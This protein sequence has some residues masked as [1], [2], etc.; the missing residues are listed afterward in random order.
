MATPSLSESRGAEAGALGRQW[1]VIAALVVMIATN[2]LANA[3]PLN[4]QT[5]GAISARFPIYFEPAGYVFSIWGLIYLGLIVYAVYQALPAQRQN[6]RLRAI[7]FPFILSCLANTTWL[8]LWHYNRFTLTQ[9]AM[10]TLLLALILIY[11]RLA[12]GRPA[13][14][15]IEKWAVHLPFS[16]YLGWVTVATVANTSIVLYD[17]GWRGGALGEP[18]WAVLM[19]LVT[20]GLTFLM[21]W[22][23][24]DVAYALV[25]VWAAAGIAV[26]QSGSGLVA[27]TA[28]AVAV[29]V[30]VAAAAARLKNRS[31][32]NVQR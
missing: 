14:S 9:A 24:G 6:P 17:W 13:A 8:F 30:A 23:H 31:T 4:N 22:R 20:A 26:K 28:V 12:A 15:T 1:L 32:L 21:L 27:G 10:V 11:R 5:T 25:I 2:I 3:L 7:A 29:L 16:V 19:L 18:V